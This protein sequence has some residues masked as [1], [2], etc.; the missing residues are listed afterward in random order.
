MLCASRYCFSCSTFILELF[1]IIV[2]PKMFQRSLDGTPFT[3]N[4]ISFNCFR[5]CC[6]MLSTL[7]LCLLVPMH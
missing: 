5:F 3:D 7:L 1:I 6:Q 4:S 2:S